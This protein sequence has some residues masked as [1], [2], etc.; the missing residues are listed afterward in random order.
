MTRWA[1]M[2]TSDA[3]VNVWAVVSLAYLVSSLTGAV[4]IGFIYH[5]SYNASIVL[6]T[7]LPYIAANNASPLVGIVEIRLAEGNSVDVIQ[8]VCEEV[9]N[10]TVGFVVVSPC[11]LLTLLEAAVGGLDVPVLGVH[12]DPCHHRVTVPSSFRVQPPSEYRHNAITSL[13]RAGGFV[14]VAILTD[15]SE[16][17]VT[18]F[19]SLLSGAFVE[20]S[21]TYMYG[22]YN[23]RT[24]TALLSRVTENDDTTTCL[25]LMLGEQSLKEVSRLLNTTEDDFEDNIAIVVPS[26]AVSSTHGLEG[27]AK[28]HDVL[29]ISAARPN[30]PSDVKSFN[31]TDAHVLDSFMALSTA[32]NVNVATADNVTTKRCGD[33]YIGISSVAQR[34]THSLRQLETNSTLFDNTGQNQMSFYNI[35][36]LRYENNTL[37]SEHVATWSRRGGLDV[38]RGT[39]LFR[40]NTK[41]LGNITLRVGTTVAAP[42]V[43]KLPNNSGWEGFC[44]DILDELAARL[45]FRYELIQSPDEFW[46]T[47]DEDGN[48][49]GV[50]E[51]ARKKSIHLGI[52]PISLTSERERVID[53]TKPYMEE[54]AGIILR[55]FEDKSSKIFRVFKPF[56]ESVWLSVAGAVLV[57][58]FTLALVNHLSP[59]KQQQQEEEGEGGSRRRGISTSDNIWIVY[60][61]YMEQG[62]EISPPNISGRFILG[63]WW[64]FTIL[65]VASYKANLVAFLTVN[66]VGKP[67][68][69]IDDLA[70]Q[71]A[72]K[73]LV[74]QG[75]NLYQELQKGETETFRKLWAMVKTA[76]SVKNNDEALDLVLTGDYALLTDQSQIEFLRMTDCENLMSGETPFNVGGLGFIVP[77]SSPLLEI[78]SLNLIQL[79][80]A[81]LTEKWRHRWWSPSATCPTSSQASTVQSLELESTSGPFLVFAGSTTLALLCLGVECVYFRVVGRGRVCG[82][83]GTRE[84]EASISSEGNTNETF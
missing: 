72:I 73:P 17:Q 1:D 25:I 46:G 30:F 15:V 48:W 7:T 83:S 67:I 78:L 82:K 63:F 50:V 18:H 16:A 74:K 44:V 27:F 61:S 42:F 71:T 32:I 53:F 70:D 65:M 69:N 66:F 64:V 12:T 31:T 81:G 23:A 49:N 38:P 20:S 37:T 56:T 2:A 51:M 11:R 33:S 41:G 9:K 84:T 80:E 35:D 19:R 8:K 76:P 57:V 59:I 43:M 75:S 55:R 14:Q 10:N 26:S 79:Q 4:N 13:L 5:E 58:G 22:G 68:R 24:A 47:V 29:Y 60:E 21:V 6:T 40:E 54:G 45:N 34:V 39:E 3:H 77:E 52:G 28:F 36:R 62:C